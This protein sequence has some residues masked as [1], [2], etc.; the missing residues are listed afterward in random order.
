MHDEID[1]M[2]SIAPNLMVKDG[3]RF[4]EQANDAVAIGKALHVEAIVTGS[5]RQ[6]AG[7]LRVI[8]KLVDTRTEANIWTKR[9]DK[10]EGE[11]FAIQRE[12]AKSVAEG[13]SIKLNAGYETPLSKRQP[14]IQTNLDDHRYLHVMKQVKG[15]VPWSYEKP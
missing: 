5:V 4:K 3:S 11:V 1:A 2:L 8:V 13:L 7:Q 9:F 6:A 10:N 12:I 15:W 14:D